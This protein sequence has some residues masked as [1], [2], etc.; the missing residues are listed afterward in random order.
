MSLASVFLAIWDA[1]PLARRLVANGSSEMDR[2]KLEKQLQEKSKVVAVRVTPDMVNALI[3]TVRF[4][5]FPHT[6]VTV[7]CIT[8][9]NGYNL[10]GY[11]ACVAKANFDAQIGE[12][13]ALEAAKEQIWALE[14]YRLADKIHQDA[15][16]DAAKKQIEAYEARGGQL[17][18]AADWP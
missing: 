9:R 3:D 16:Y 1:S 13:L 15:M 5:Q 8:L 18:Q 10:V 7:C 14:G 6:T 12:E 4:Y 2:D 17:P 11:S